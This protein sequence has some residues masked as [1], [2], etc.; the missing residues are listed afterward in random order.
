MKRLL[1]V[2]LFFI[3]MA[4]AVAQDMPKEVKDL[5]WMV[6]T[7]SASGK[8]AFGGQETQ[9]DSTLTA[10]FDGQF[11]KIVS[12]DKSS[13]YTLTKTAMIGWDAA[14]S[15]YVSYTFTNMAPKARIAHGKMDGNKL[16]MITEPWEAE[17]MTMVAR[18][19]LSK[20]PDSKLGSMLEMKNG[21]KWL[22]GMDFV[23]TKK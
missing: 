4:A 8:I 10:S 20:L 13:Q 11:L 5:G 17:G 3:P 2:A 14:K 22:T 7:W 6:G 12:S 1:T 16:V 15:E 18:E 21:E 9:I 19:T 23:L